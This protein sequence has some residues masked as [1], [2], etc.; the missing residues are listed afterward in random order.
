MRAEHQVP[1]DPTVSFCPLVP[2]TILSPVC[3]HHSS[4][5]NTSY[6]LYQAENTCHTSC[7]RLLQNPLYRRVF[8]G[9]RYSGR[10]VTSDRPGR[11]TLVCATGAST[12][13]ATSA[14][15]YAHSGLKASSL[16]HR[17]PAQQ[18]TMHLAPCTG[19]LP[20]CPLAANGAKAD[21]LGAV[22]MVQQ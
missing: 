14:Y 4:Y 20:L 3:F 9:I 5:I 7:P 21:R 16:M 17:R 6:T 18:C 11:R 12:G 10:A 19:A 8:C 1:L 13:A 22:R 15:D 2:L